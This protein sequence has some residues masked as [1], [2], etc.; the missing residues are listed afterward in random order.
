M[1]NITF[2]YPRYKLAIHIFVFLLCAWSIFN[3]ISLAPKTLPNETWTDVYISSIFIIT[4]YALAWWIIPILFSNYKKGILYVALYIIIYVVSLA[5]LKTLETIN[6]NRLKFIDGVYYAFRAFLPFAIIAFAYSSIIMKKELI[7]R[8]FSVKYLEKT[9][10]SLAI[11]IPYLYYFLMN[12]NPNLNEVLTISLF[13]FIFYINVF[14]LTSILFLK[15]DYFKYCLS[16][17]LLSS[18]YFFAIWS[19]GYLKFDNN[20]YVIIWSLSLA[21]IILIST[22]YGYLRLKSKES[23]LKFIDQETELQL[24][25][26]QVNPHFLFNTLNTLY[27]TALNENAP[28]SAESIAKLASLIRYMQ[29]DITKD[30]IPLANEIKYLEDYIAI[31]KLRCEVIPSIKTHFSNIENQYISPGLF[32]PFVENAFKYGID[33]SKPSKLSVS[34]VCVEGKV[35]FE[36]VNSYDDS[37]KTYYKEQGFGLGI[38]NAKQRLKLIYPK[39]HLIEI[40]KEN[41]TFSVIIN[42]TSIEK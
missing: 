39:K 37:F 29:E 27:A 5:F 8:V 33:P 22:T 35:K 24:L 13:I 34:V 30:Y 1:K 32:I 18:I 14:F 20:L 25:K 17:I 26:S 42:I 15:K 31:Q 3:V 6:G 19:F 40:N 41:Q 12:N 11:F 16:I 21:S 2:F 23:K 28:K 9:L 10:N 38:A 4:I 36:C 7:N